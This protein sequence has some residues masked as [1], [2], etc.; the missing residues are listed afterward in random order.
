MGVRSTSSLLRNTASDREGPAGMGKKWIS[1]LAML[2][3]HIHTSADNV[4]VAEYDASCLVHD[5]A[6]GEGKG[7]LAAFNAAHTTDTYVDDCR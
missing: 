7:W 3:L 5:E 2:V 1:L 4:A 6:S